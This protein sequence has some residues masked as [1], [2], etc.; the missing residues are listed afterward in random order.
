[1]KT[2]FAAHGKPRILLA[3]DHPAYV[4]LLRR[5]LARQCEIVG[6]VSDGE[7]LLKCAPGLQPDVVI[8]DLSMP[9]IAGTDAGSKLRALV[10]DTKILVL[11]ASENSELASDLLRTWAS[12]F[13]LKKSA[14]E[15]LLAAIDQILLGRKYI[16]S[17]L[18]KLV[19]RL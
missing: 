1:M 11:T 15:E 14:A 13:L 17:H 8:L 7:S 12:G 19:P 4:E 2:R 5:L 6:S 9:R 16:D 18:K 3:D 10:P